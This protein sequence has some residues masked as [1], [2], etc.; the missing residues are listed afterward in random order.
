[1][2][3][4]LMLL[5]GVLIM[6]Q[7]SEPSAPPE[8]TPTPTPSVCKNCG[9]L[10]GFTDHNGHTNQ[11]MDNGVWCVFCMLEAEDRALAYLRR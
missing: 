10:E 6:L 1:M 3:L 11:L 4:T 9:R 5:F 2:L 8:P 7:S